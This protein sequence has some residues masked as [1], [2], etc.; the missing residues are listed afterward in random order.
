MTTAE[1]IQLFWNVTVKIF[2]GFGGWYSVAVFTAGMWGLK[3][4]LRIN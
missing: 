4:Y 3:K 1:E 2:N